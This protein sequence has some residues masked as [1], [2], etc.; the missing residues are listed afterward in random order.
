M[1][2]DI[3]M[4]AGEYI[5]GTLDS[6]ERRAFQRRLLADPVAVAAVATWQERLSPLLLAVPDIAAPAT[7]WPRIEA[8]SAAAN[9]NRVRRW[10]LAT[11]A[12]A[13]VALVTTGLALRPLPK[14]APQPVVA[15]Q[16]LLQSVAALSESGGAPALLVTYDPVSTKMRVTPVNVSPRPGHSMELWVIAGKAAP[17]SIGLMQDEGATALDR[18]ALDMHEQ[19]TI[20]VSVEPKGGSPTGLPTGPVVYSGRMITLPT[21]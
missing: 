10:Q 9:D 15:Q 7:L 18:M 14:P 3:D 11:A 8:G 6:A 16:P 1:A 13:L 21:S 4:I 5:L 17:R 19:L 20:A 2:E 12:A